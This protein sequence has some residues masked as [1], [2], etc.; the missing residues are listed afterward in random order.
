M[1][2]E[3]RLIKK[4]DYNRVYKY[5]KSTTNHQFVLF[6]LRNNQ[7]ENFRLGISV[8]RKVGNAVVRNRVRRL[9]KEIVRSLKPCIAG[10]L[11]MILLAR[12]PAAQMDFHQMEKSIVHVLKKAS[13]Y[14]QVKEEQK[15][16]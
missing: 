10:H 13:V 12:K 9:V 6:V 5:G 2:K 8:S 11:D 3:Y 4:A 14:T 16:P 15:K 7:I 1:E